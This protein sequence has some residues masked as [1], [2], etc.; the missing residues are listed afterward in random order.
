[1]SYLFWKEIL[2]T[3]F[4]LIILCS[5]DCSMQNHCNG[6]GMCDLSL[7]KCNCF[8]GWGASTDV[9]LY[10]APD[11]SARTCPS[12]RA[13]SDIPT[14]STTAHNVAECANRGTCDRT[15][16]TC[17]CFPGFTGTACERS[18][19]PNDCSGH[20]ICVSMKQMARMDNALP[21]AP[22]TFYE[23]YDDSVTWDEDMS[24]GCVCDSSWTVGLGN[25]ETQQSEWFGP[26]CSMRRCP[27]GDDPFTLIVETNCTGRKAANSIHS[28][29]EGNLCHIDCSNRGLCDYKTGVCQC[30]NGLYGSACNIIDATAVYTYWS[31]GRGPHTKNYERV[32]IL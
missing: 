10:R 29:A 9:T 32:D 13:W 22:N 24:Y 11:C 6:H 20:G 7:N 17:K 2:L 28:G 31:K 3:F 4:M 1:M 26:D 19:C 12:W 8:E 5:S 15:T 14:S 21:L 30:F 16:G 23:G 25:G 18:R 27:S